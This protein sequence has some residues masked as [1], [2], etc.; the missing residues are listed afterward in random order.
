MKFIL[1]P[2]LTSFWANTIWAFTICSSRIQPE[3][4]PNK[5]GKREKEKLAPKTKQQTA[6]VTSGIRI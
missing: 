3:T 1:E 2:K 4:R 6:Q 5:K